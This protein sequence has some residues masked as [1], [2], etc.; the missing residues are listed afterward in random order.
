MNHE[1]QNPNHVVCGMNFKSCRLYPEFTNSCLNQT[2][3]LFVPGK[4]QLRLGLHPTLTDCAS[5]HVKSISFFDI[6]HLFSQR[7]L[8]TDRR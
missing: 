7:G 5:P 8:P 6:S 1:L 4:Q 2:L 3:E